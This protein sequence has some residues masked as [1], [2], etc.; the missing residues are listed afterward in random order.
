M[1]KHLIGQTMLMETGE[2]NGQRTFIIVKVLEA[3]K[4]GML[5]VETVESESELVLVHNSFLSSPEWAKLA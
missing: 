3:R 1:N 5:L 4:E 2:Y